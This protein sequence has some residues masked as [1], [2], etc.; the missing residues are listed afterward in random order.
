MT[1]KRSYSPVESAST[2]ACWV[3]D[4]VFVT[5]AS[6]LPYSAID[7]LRKSSVVCEYCYTTTGDKYLHGMIRADGSLWRPTYAEYLKSHQWRVLRKMALEYAGH[8]CQVCNSDLMLQVHHRKYP[9]T[10]G[11]EAISDLTVLCRRC[12]DLFH[13]V[14]L[15]RG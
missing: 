4:K 15:S 14:R 8:H 13:D 3:C 9:A 7:A 10:L 12:H 11:S 1:R 5:A 6:D 2:F